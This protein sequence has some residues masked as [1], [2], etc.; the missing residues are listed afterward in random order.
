MSAELTPSL[1]RLFD[2][3]RAARRAHSELLA[4]D[5]AQLLAALEGAVK[6]ALGM[7]DEPER[8]LRLARIA[9]LL[10]ELH[11]PKPVDLLIDILGCEAPEAR[12]AGGEALEDL[13]Y[14]RFKEVALGVERALERLPVGHLALAE[15]PYLLADIPEPGVLKLIGRFLAHK[16]PDAVAGGLEA[17]VEIGDPAGSGMLAPL[18]KDTRQVVLEDD[19]GEE[20]RVTIGELAKEARQ[21]LES[22]GAD[23]PGNGRPRPEGKQQAPSRGPA[24]R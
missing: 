24:R 22:H 4:A 18:E 2:A 14:D 3:E 8:A 11:G 6:E 10:S 19:E 20:G 7:S 12:H 13:A 23:E 15:L 9:P 21:L 1:Q 5:P 17:L 16:D